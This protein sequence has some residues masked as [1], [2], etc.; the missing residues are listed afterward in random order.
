[1]AFSDLQ[2]FA[3]HYEPQ[4]VSAR[5]EEIHIPHI[6]YEAVKDYGLPSPKIVERGWVEMTSG[7]V[8]DFIALYGA[9]ATSITTPLHG[10]FTNCIATEVRPPSSR[11]K[12]PRPDGFGGLTLKFCGEYE[13]IW[14]ADVTVIS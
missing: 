8:D 12:H 6:N 3:I 10:T 9:P 1:M 14:I 13:I 2:R 4:N 11:S 7:I 5:H